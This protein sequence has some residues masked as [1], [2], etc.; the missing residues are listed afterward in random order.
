[1]VQV[2][3]CFRTTNMESFV[4]MIFWNGKYISHSLEKRFTSLYHR[5]LDRSKDIG[6]CMLS[7][8]EA[9]TSKIPGSVTKYTFPK[10]YPSDDLHSARVESVP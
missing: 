10:F 1:M 5:S 3:K 6:V 4:D 2:D 7:I 8:R 9:T